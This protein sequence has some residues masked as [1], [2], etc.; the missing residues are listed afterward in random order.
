MR[1]LLIRELD[2]DFSRFVSLPETLFLAS[3][4][5][6]FPRLR[7]VNSITRFDRGVFEAYQLNDDL[8]A[9]IP[10]TI[11]GTAFQSSRLRMGRS[12]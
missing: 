12:I 6:K 7:F 10:G 3:V 4:C 8:R 9:N 11:L 1:S 5:R 2:R